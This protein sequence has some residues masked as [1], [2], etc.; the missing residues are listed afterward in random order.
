LVWSRARSGF[1]RALALARE[2]K[3]GSAELRAVMS[4]ARLTG[5]RDEARAALTGIFGWLADA[6]DAAGLCEPK[7]CLT[8]SAS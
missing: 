4:L 8:S 1:E 6:P 7:R 3:A 5:G 2:Q